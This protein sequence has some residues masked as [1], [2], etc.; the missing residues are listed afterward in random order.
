MKTYRLTKPKG[1]DK[2]RAPVPERDPILDYL[3]DAKTGT[4][5]NFVLL[6]GSSAHRRVRE[7]IRQG[8][9]EEVRIGDF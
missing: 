1:R 9:I 7:L 5:D 3:Y 2:A 6:V 4:M 8:Y